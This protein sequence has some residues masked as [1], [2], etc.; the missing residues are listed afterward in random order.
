[1]GHINVSIPYTTSLQCV[2]RMCLARRL[3]AVE[4]DERWVENV[5]KSRLRRRV[6][7]MNTVRETSV[8]RETNKRRDAK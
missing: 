8:M 3:D 7:S 1:M 2:S 6:K 4:V 5:E